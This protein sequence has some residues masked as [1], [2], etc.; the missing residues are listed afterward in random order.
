MDKIKNAVVPIVIGGSK[1]WK[2]CKPSILAYCKKYDLPLEVITQCKYGIEPFN[3][4]SN[5]INL[6]E[7]NQIYELFDK[8]DRILRLDYDLIISP[9][10][11]N[12]FDIVPEDKIGGVYEDVG[13]AKLSRRK[14]IIDI[15]IHLGG[16]L[17]WI[18]GYMNAGVVVASKEHREVF[19]TSIEEINEVQEIPDIITP[20]QDYF[21]YMIR[22]LGFGIYELDYKFNHIRYFSPNRFDSYIIHY[23]GSGVYDIDLQLK[24]KNNVNNKLWRKM[25]AKQMRRD[26]KEIIRRCE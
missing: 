18:S 20:E 8:Y 17:G 22:K 5:S 14:M 24:Q 23:A 21:N 3:P 19:N 2:V 7:K 9:N 4:F 26:Y 1:E 6:F 13:D 25:T 15:Q 11:P 10:C 12:L 16:N